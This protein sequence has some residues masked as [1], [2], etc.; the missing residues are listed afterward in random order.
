M[1]P[2]G[3]TV[4]LTPQILGWVEAWGPWLVALLAFLETAFITGLLIPCGPVLIA[5]VAL[6]SEGLLELEWIVVAA[7]SGALAGDSVGYWVGARGGGH[8]A[9]TSGRLGRLARRAEPRARRLF[10]R[11]PF[12]AVTVARLVSF[13]RTLM[14]PAA[15]LGD[16][17]Y[18]RFLFWDV[19]GVLLWAAL[20]VGIGLAA[21]GGLSFLDRILG[22][23]GAIAAV[24]LVGLALWTLRRRPGRGSAGVAE[25]EGGV[26]VA[27]DSPHLVEPERR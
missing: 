14:P 23:G 4:E 2:P 21:E 1:R 9:R 6:A 12:F 3:A 10:G 27:E 18:S 5:A 11:H 19:L 17:R 8:A 20:Y 24:V 16:L 13:V 7:I 15:G 26:E 22:T 25:P